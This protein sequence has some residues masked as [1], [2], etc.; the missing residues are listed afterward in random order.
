MKTSIMVL[1]LGLLAACMQRDPQGRAVQFDDSSFGQSW[2]HLAYTGHWEHMRGLRD[3]R[4]DGTSSRSRFPGDSVVVPFQGSIVRVYGVRGP[5]G[6]DASIGIDG[7]YYGVATFFAP[8]KQVRALVFQSPQLRE[9]PHILALVVERPAR[10]A[11][12]YVNID[13]VEVLHRQ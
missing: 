12:G 7:R 5:N 1:A 3:G 13:Q 4:A 8:D 11:R 6:G 10:A 2:D 9:G